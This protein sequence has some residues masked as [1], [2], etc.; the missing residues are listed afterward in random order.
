MCGLIVRL[1]LRILRQQQSS[2]V[3][4]RS[5]NTLKASDEALRRLNPP[6]STLQALTE[7]STRRRFQFSRSGSE[8]TL[9]LSPPSAGDVGGPDPGKDAGGLP[10]RGEPGQCVCA[11]LQGAL[12]GQDPADGGRR[13]PA[14]PEDMT[15]TVQPSHTRTH[16][17]RGNREVAATNTDSELTFF[18]FFFNLFLIQHIQ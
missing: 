12:V 8:H 11:E 1:L 10:G 3:L 6:E 7:V 9:S 17:H 13:G 4:Q 2:F 5:E 15:N 16:T 18:F 14:S